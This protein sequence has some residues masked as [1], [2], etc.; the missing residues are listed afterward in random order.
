MHHLQWKNVERAEACWHVARYHPPAR[1]RSSMHDHDF[2]EVMWIEAGHCQHKRRTGSD[3]LHRGDVV[4]IRPA[5]AHALEAQET[6]LIFVNVAFP[7]P[8][9]DS[10]R[11]RYF[12]AELT[13]ANAPSNRAG[14]SEDPA[15]QWPWDQRRPQP[16]RLTLDGPRLEMLGRWADQLS[17]MRQVRIEIDAF[18][19]TLLNLVNGLWSSLPSELGPLTAAPPWLAQALR[20]FDSPRHLPGGPHELAA[21]A[22]KSV[23]HVNRV[24]RQTLGKT[25]TQLVND[26]RLRFAARELRMTWRPILDIALDCG[27]SHQGY[28]YRHFRQRY[29]CTPRQYRLRART[30]TAPPE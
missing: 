12:P 9:L 2:A 26:L 20:R 16:L 29:N 18:L 13:A 22:G 15:L 1:F 19:L 7:L 30:S 11:Q 27:M 14:T 23:E 25:T 6:G 24:V 8:V 17:A 21:L 5:D 28:F 10:I 3:T 4:F